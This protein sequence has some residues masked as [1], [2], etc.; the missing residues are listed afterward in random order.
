MLDTY[1]LI[2]TDENDGITYVSLVDMPAVEV[3]WQCYGK[4]EKPVQFTVTEE[5]VIMGVVMIPDKLIHRCNGGYEYQVYYSKETVKKM[6]EQMLR[7]GTYK[8]VD[9][10]HN[11]DT[12]GSKATL[13]EVFLKDDS[14]GISPRGFEDLPDG[15]M[16]CTYHIN[17]EELWGMCKDGT[18]TGFSL[19]GW[20]DS[21]PVEHRKQ[22]N[23][24]N[25]M[26]KNLKQ[27][28]AKILLEFGELETAQGTLDFEGEEIAV[29]IEV[30]IGETPA[31]DGEYTTDTQ[32]ITVLEGKIT[33]IVEIEA[34]EDDTTVETIE[35]VEMEEE[36]PEEET[37]TLQAELDALKE[38]VANLTA[39]LEA[40]KEAVAKE[41]PAP[42]QEEFE[43]H[44]TP[45]SRLAETLKKIRKN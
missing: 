44:V 39:E 35:E 45:Q 38:T 12:V 17:D 42:I 27:K 30:Y 16:F 36:T 5:H 25:N 23:T 20:F 4:S 2:L 26:L 29:G 10:N 41:T 43:K 11:N 28:L 34:V 1:E 33:E 9:L 14:K 3:G 22:K 13:L 32:K 8:Y 37:G 31:P 21:V 7:N 6:C 19:E 40:L 15:T 18:F 24:N